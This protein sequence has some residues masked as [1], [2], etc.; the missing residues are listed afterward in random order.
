M[1][2]SQYL[3]QLFS[4]YKHFEFLIQLFF[5]SIWNG[6]SVCILCVS[7]AIG[8]KHPTQLCPMSPLFGQQE[9]IWSR[10]EWTLP[11]I[12]MESSFCLVIIIFIF[13]PQAKD[14]RTNFRW[15]EPKTAPTKFKISAANYAKTTLKAPGTHSFISQVMI[16]FSL[17]KSQPTDQQGSIWS[18]DEANVNIPTTNHHRRRQYQPTSLPSSQ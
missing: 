7:V 13:R 14:F 10:C 5:L 17:P 15:Q 11:I 2:V 8:K 12:F 3:L 9:S 18:S 6:L 16:G 1:R 4:L